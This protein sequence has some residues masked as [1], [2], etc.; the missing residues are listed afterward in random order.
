M[1]R[2]S[3]FPL[4][5]EKCLICGAPWLGG[6][7]VPGTRYPRAGL[8]VFFRCGASMS[9]IDRAKELYG[10]DPASAA[11]E[12]DGYCYFL[13]LKNCCSKDGVYVEGTDRDGSEDQ[14][15]CQDDAGSVGPSDN[16][17]VQG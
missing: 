10:N 8:R 5:P 1:E 2:I 14:S 9:I 4:V 3:P 6:C 13:R 11:Y 16:V 17:E 15:Q 7:A 12:D